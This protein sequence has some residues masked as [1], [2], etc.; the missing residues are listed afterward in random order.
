MRRPAASARTIVVATIAGIFATVV[1]TTSLG[2]QASS[3]SYTTWSYAARLFAL[4]NDARQQHGEQPLALVPGTTEVATGWTQHLA[5]AGA[6]S[7]NPQL[8]HQLSVHGSR[9]WLTYGE[10]VG[11]G[12]A[13]DPDG[14]FVAYMNS[15]EH[16]ANILS[17][18]YRFVGVAVVFTGSRA[19][20]TFDFVDVYGD[21]A[22]AARRAIPG[23]PHLRSISQARQTAIA[24]PTTTTVATHPVAAAA[25]TPST[26]PVRS[27]Q[28]AARPIG[29]V[30]VHVKALRNSVGRLPVTD[31]AAS[32][33]ATSW[34]AG[35][36][37]DIHQV[38][39]GRSLPIAVA[40]AV[41]ALMFAARRWVLVAG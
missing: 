5:G 41:L 35:L 9:A 10:N 39:D 37:A 34:S 3:S 22:S 6:L 13:D 38:P 1:L 24:R 31:V 32:L 33:P 14:L 15:P 40:I 8:A 28:R 26:P 36:V 2:A 7:H 18:E 25:A 11:V 4:V 30:V 19:W 17:S 20:N 16:R 23:R 21:S 12:S 27:T 29:P